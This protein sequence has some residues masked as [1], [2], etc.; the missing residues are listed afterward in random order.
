MRT[1]WAAV[2]LVLGCGGARGA[3]RPAPELL[4]LTLRESAAS[5]EKSFGPHSH[6]ARGGGYSVLDFGADSSEH[7]DLGF[8][9]TFYFEQPSGELLSV[10]HNLPEAR[11]V[12]A[13]F[14][15]SESRKHHGRGVSALSRALS[16]DRVL[17]AI[18]MVERGS[19][20]SQLILMRRSVVERFYPW[21]AEG[22]K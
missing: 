2:A 12:D 3:D 8:E 18:G 4:K 5:I 21:I 7:N 20:C 22:L 9:W 15:A 6:S 10:T 19:G 16:G 17:I 13:L 14:P 1:A 11:N